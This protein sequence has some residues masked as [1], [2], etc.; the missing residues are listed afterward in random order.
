MKVSGRTIQWWVYDYPRLVEVF[1]KYLEIKGGD[2]VSADEKHNKPKGKARWMTRWLYMATR[3]ILAS[4]HWP[5]KLN[6]NATPLMVKIV[7]R[8]G[9]LPCCCSVTRWKDTRRGTKTR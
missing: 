1:S 3:Y 6:H 2:V 8:L 5:D 7:E 9:G 4:D